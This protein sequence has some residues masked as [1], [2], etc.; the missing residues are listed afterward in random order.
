MEVMDHLEMT[1][2]IKRDDFNSYVTRVFARHYPDMFFNLLSL[3][4]KT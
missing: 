3:V 1:H 2:D 4:S